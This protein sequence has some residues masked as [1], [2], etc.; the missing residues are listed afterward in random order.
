MVRPPY[1]VAW[2]LLLVAISN[3]AELDGEAVLK[4]QDLLS[5][6]CDRFFNV[7]THMVFRG[8]HDEDKRREL[9]TEL[10]RPLPGQARQEPSPEERKQIND[11]W[12]SF[13]Q[14]I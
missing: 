1:R 8:V 14:G 3:W 2:R 4:G 5:L 11:E 9:E 7:I 10:N 13:M 6:R 12:S